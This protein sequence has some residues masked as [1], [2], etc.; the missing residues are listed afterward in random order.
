MGFNCWQNWGSSC[1]CN[2]G[3][4]QQCGFNTWNQQC[5]FN[6]WNQQCGFNTW[7]QQCGFNPI[8]CRPTCCNK[9]RKRDWLNSGGWIKGSCNFCKRS[10]WSDSDDCNKSRDCSDSER[11]NDSSDLNECKL[12]RR[13]WSDSDNCV[14]NDSSDGDPGRKRRVRRRRLR[15]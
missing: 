3:L 1:L 10:S 8:S 7:N 5:G 12:R 15:A 14:Q 13:E 9:F 6:P 11:C 2:S 4:G